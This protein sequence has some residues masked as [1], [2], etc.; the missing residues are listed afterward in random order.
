VE[1]LLRW[2]HPAR[3]LVSP[4]QVIRIAEQT[5]LIVPLGRWVLDEACRQAT[6][7]P[8]RMAVNISSLHLVQTGLCADLEAALESAGL[9][10]RAVARGELPRDAS[11][12]GTHVTTSSSCRTT[13]DCG[14]VGAGAASGW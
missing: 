13:G 7:W 1:A 3:G 6:R 10:R 8:V 5:G 4:A 9:P 12:W 11:R 2:D 14:S